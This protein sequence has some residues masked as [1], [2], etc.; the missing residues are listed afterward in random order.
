MD[1]LLFPSCRPPCL[2]PQRNR[3]QTDIAKRCLTL[4]ETLTTR[5]VPEQPV[6]PRN[7]RVNDEPMFEITARVV[8]RFSKRETPSAGATKTTSGAGMKAFDASRPCHRSPNPIMAKNS[9]GW[10]LGAFRAGVNGAGA[11]PTSNIP[12]DPGLYGAGALCRAATGSAPASCRDSRKSRETSYGR[13]SP[14]RHISPAAG[15]AGIWSPPAPHR[16]LASPTGRC[17]GR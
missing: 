10:K 16:A 17:R 12:R 14:P 6:P 3:N 15:R 11:S 4:G 7:C 1:I 13:A 2:R 9:A 8:P 5:S